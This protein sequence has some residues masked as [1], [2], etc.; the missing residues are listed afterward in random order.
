MCAATITQLIHCRAC[1]LTNRVPGHWQSQRQQPVCE[2][3][4]SRLLS[5][6]RLPTIT[7]ANYATT[8][9]R[10]QLPVLLDLWAPWCGPCHALSPVIEQLASE[11]AGRV[12]VVKLNVDEN[13]LLS[14]RFSVRSIPTLLMI[15]DGHEVDRLVGVQSK[16]EIV[17]RLQTLI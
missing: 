10:S 4:Q 6:H 11:L 2:R 9:E 5:F 8:V 3:C 15:K 1:G 13:P 17:R 14:S 12:R 7:D 16:A